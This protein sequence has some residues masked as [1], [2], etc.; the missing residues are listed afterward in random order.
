[1]VNTQCL[2]ERT[3]EGMG[4]AQ[5]LGPHLGRLQGHF[6]PSLQ[7]SSREARAGHGGE[8]EAEVLVAGVRADALH[9]ALQA[10]HPAHSQVAVLQAHPLPLLHAC[11]QHLLSL[12]IQC[13]CDERPN[14]YKASDWHAT[15][16]LYVQAEA[17]VAMGGL[18]GCFKTCV[19]SSAC[20][21]V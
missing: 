14:P 2:S 19:I 6:D 11:Y 7:D 12:H 13:S 3:T 15:V 16:F 1:M 10:G 4:D 18:L 8:P 21:S 17:C 5:G 9:N 20:T